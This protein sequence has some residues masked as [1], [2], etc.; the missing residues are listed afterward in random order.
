MMPPDG[1]EVLAGHDAILLGAVGDPSTPDHVSL[2]GLLIPIRRAFDQYVNL[3]PSVLLPGVTSPLRDT[4]RGIDVLVVR[5][6]SEGEYSEVGGRIGRGTPHETAVQEAV[7]TRRGTE[8]IIEYAVEQARSRRG[9]LTSAHQVQRDHPLDDLLG[10]GLH[11][12][13]GPA[14][15]TWRAG[16]STSTPSPRAWSATP[17]SSTSWSAPTSSA[18]CCRTSGPPWSGASASPRRPTSTPPGRHPS[19]FEPVHGSAPDIAGRGR[20]Q[21][22]RPRSGPRR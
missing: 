16:S 13:P 6:N 15:P 19:M 17:T 18:T 7:F 5:E 11:R 4:G 1:L 12:G 3:R 2:W 21:P 14:T 8:R 9:L 22:A 10:R 20:R